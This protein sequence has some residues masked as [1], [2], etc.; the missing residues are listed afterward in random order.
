VAHG[1]YS[2]VPESIR[3]NVLAAMRAA[4]AETGI[5]FLSMNALPGWELRRALRILMR[6]AAA[7]AADPGEKVRAALA[8]VDDLASVS[9]DG[10]V[11]VLAKAAQEYRA[12]VA[13]A[14]PAEA[15]FSHYVFHDLLAEC[16]DAFSVADL[17]ARLRVH[18]LRILCETPLLRA[19]TDPAAEADVRWL[20]AQ[21]TDSGSPFLQ[22]LVCRDEAATAYAPDRVL[23]AAREMQLWADLAP[24][25]ASS[26]RTT[27]GA[28]LRA[29][30]DA[31]LARA[32]RSAPGFVP[33]RSLADDEASLAGIARDLFV[34][35]CDGLLT[36]ASEP[37]PIAKR[38]SAPLVT[39]HVRLRARAA[40]AAHA[41]SAVLTNAL[42]RSF[43]VPW[44]ELV[45]IRELDGETDERELRARVRR[46]IAGGS[47]ELAGHALAG[48]D[49]RAIAEHVTIVLDRFE[50]HAFFVDREE[51]AT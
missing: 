48:A 24:A 15:P 32:A 9:G 18:G 26:F 28:I 16:N 23:T 2:W 4:L 40:S 20:A 50:R 22:V 39:P 8:L 25:S 46:A 35:S 49:E 3:G 43:R 44:R 45:V 38:S 19:R 30:G 14:T 31:G 11:S 17:E 27:T 1:V 37:F 6:E 42:H 12:H 10:F 5:G 13:Q 47:A 7:S 41:P 21:L 33:I 51:V 29:T 36:I 34:A